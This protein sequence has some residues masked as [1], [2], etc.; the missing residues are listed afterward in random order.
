METK[1]PFI[2]DSEVEES[3]E[4]DLACI[5]VRRAQHQH[6]R[7]YH[8][9]RAQLWPG[10]GRRRRWR[11]RRLSDQVSD[12]S[13]GFNL[14]LQITMD[15]LW[16][17]F[18][19][20]GLLPL[21]PCLYLLLLYHFSCFFF[22][23][24]HSHWA[25]LLLSHLSLWRSSFVSLS[26]KFRIRGVFLFSDIFEFSF[27]F[28]IFLDFLFQIHNIPATKTKRIISP[29]NHMIYNIIFHFNT[30]NELKRFANI[31]CLH[32]YNQIIY[33]VS[34]IYTC[35]YKNTQWIHF[36]LKLF[37]SCEYEHESL[38]WKRSLLHTSSKMITEYWLSIKTK[39]NVGTVMVSRTIKIR[40]VVYKIFCGRKN[41]WREEQTPE[42]GQPLHVQITPTKEI[43]TTLGHFKIMQKK[44][45]ILIHLFSVKNLFGIF[46]VLFL[47]KNL[48]KCTLTITFLS[49]Q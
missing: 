14:G 11:R 48:K 44:K 26:L 17:D 27:S 12:I 42:P 31:S 25:L 22:F 34:K 3:E 19:H 10:L 39:I 2:A 35:K 36:L 20:K 7:W 49:I 1:L 46:L 6:Q 29:K 32:V 37:I 33:P 30:S 23:F 24:S 13:G 16:G 8:T 21:V 47:Y 4:R 9:S 40:V 15:E 18:K 41:I 45:T 5:W 28:M 43:P 38:M